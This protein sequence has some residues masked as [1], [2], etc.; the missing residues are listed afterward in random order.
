MTKRDILSV[1]LLSIFT[2]GIYSIYWMY[3][4]AEQLNSLESEEPLTNYILA[5]VLG[6]LT[7]GIYSIYWQYKFYKKVDSVTS[8]NNLVINFILSILGL[9]L[10]SMAIAQTSFNNMN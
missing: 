6:I 3:V 7:C 9:S 4:S 8:E 2:C 5:I 10:V 1:I